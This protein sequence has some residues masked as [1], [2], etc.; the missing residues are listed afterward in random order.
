MGLLVD[1]DDFAF[2]VIAVAR[3]SR[4]SGRPVRGVVAG[5][6]KDAGEQTRN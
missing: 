5:D 1:G 6:C 2:E 3:L 4:L